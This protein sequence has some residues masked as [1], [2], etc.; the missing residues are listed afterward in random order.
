[1]LLVDDDP[2]FLLSSGVA[3]RAGGVHPVATIEDSRNVMRFLEEREAAVVVL[4]LSMPHVS[5]ME[6]LG[7]M[8]E[9]YPEMPVLVMTGRNEVGMAVEC[10]K[11]GAF[12][13][14]VKP[15]EMNR[16]VASIRSAREL[17]SLRDEVTTLKRH[18]LSGQVENESAFAE[19]LTQDRKMLA[20]FQYVE[21]IAR[22]GHPILVTGE[23]GTGKELV[24]RAIHALSGRKGE[25][26]AVNVAGLED[27]MF[28]DTLF[29]HRRGAYTGA[30]QA[31]EG[32]IAKAAG[33]TFFLDEIGDLRESSQVK[34]LR[35][36]EERRYYPLG[37][38]AAKETDARIVCATHRDL[39]K[40]VAGGEFR[41][42]LYYRLSAHH[43]R[44]PSLRERPGDIPLLVEH[45]L[46]EAAQAEGKRKPTAPPELSVLLANYPFP[47]NVRE[48]RMM[49]TDAVLRHKG[50][51]LS[52]DSFRR[53]TGMEGTP[54]VAS[55]GAGVPS[56][57]PL[58][59]SSRL[60]TLKEA[61][62][63]L[64]STALARARNNQ[65]IAASLLGITR[66]ALNK[67]LVRGGRGAKD[68]GGAGGE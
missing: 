8:K 50:G 57:S 25:L 36:L 29:G 21:A 61:E 15:V 1:M 20:V 5:G 27:A 28:S 26:V 11:A 54:A 19:I 7:R 46:A 55:D 32:L 66:Q 37:S 30:D 59:S 63:Y 10:M 18:F 65:G 13:Y 49:V 3:L 62:E 60:P 42:D 41:R 48:L 53:A 31:R 16:F 44:I 43:V 64:I 14:L 4:D 68:A 58:F 17:R 2:Q 6:L 51:V 12:D 39:Q 24:A 35:L 33:G 56:S 40:A 9:R 23:T 47:G 22:S 45:F 38:D 34:L 67:R 52:M